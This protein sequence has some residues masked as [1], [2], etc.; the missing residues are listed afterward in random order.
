MT[1]PY[2]FLGLLGSYLSE[3][4]PQKGGDVHMGLGPA[5][6]SSNL[7]REGTLKKA[8]KILGQ[9]ICCLEPSLSVLHVTKGKLRAMENSELDLNTFIC[10]FVCLFIIEVQLSAFTSLYPPPP[11]PYPPPS[12]VSTTPWFCPCV[13]YRCS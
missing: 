7:P 12:P 8:A 5:P 10:L 3:T 6:R 9:V 11:Q 4:S 1:Y 2:P 13:L